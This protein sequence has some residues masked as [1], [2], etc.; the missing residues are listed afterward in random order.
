MET[1]ITHM[2]E[3]YISSLG[4]ERTDHLKLVALRP[5]SA[6][7]VK[8]LTQY[9]DDSITVIKKRVHPK[10]TRALFA[11]REFGGFI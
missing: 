3:K 6:G 8:V 9:E 1:W 10:L 7:Y 5:L 11:H 2:G 4:Y